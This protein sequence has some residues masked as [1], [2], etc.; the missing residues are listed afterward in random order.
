MTGPS[1]TMTPVPP[2]PEGPS[3]PDETG[4]APTPTPSS[5]WA[6]A[7]LAIGVVT[8][9]ALFLLAGLGPLL[10]VITA[11]LVMVMVHELGHFATAKWSRMKVTEYFVGFGP[12]LWSVR[13]GET[14]YGIKAIPAGGYV[15]IPGMSNM[16]EIDPAEED[17][18][19]RQAPFHNRIIVACAGSFMHFLMAFLLA[20]SA[21]LYFGTPTTAL[22]VE[23]TGFAHWPGHAQTAAQEAGLRVGDRVTAIN[24]HAIKETAKTT[25]FDRAINR[26]IGRPLHL[27]VERDGRVVHLTVTPQ[28]GHRVGT[29]GEAL[30]AG[31]HGAIGL[32]GVHPDPQPIFVSEGAFGALG[33]AAVNIGQ[34]TSATVR[35]VP[36]GVGSL[37]SSIANPKE[38]QQSAQNGTRAES[39][40]GA[41]R[42]A[43]QAEQSGI[44]Y[45]IDILIALNI[46]LGLLNMLPMLPL[47]G[48]HVAIAVYERV[49][50]RRGRPYYQAD[51]K[52]LLPVVYAFSAALVVVVVAALYLD[53]VHPVA[54]PF[55]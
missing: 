55:P 10:I 33:T 18:T 40:V 42:T 23:V 47:D 3:G 5:A 6:L 22:G 17:R 9:V 20:Y 27:T 52:K 15:K 45:L 28:A 39:I 48:G 50:T 4:A 44:L 7:R 11:V 1:S 31:K 2:A 29:T 41:V 12:R 25:Q 53:I 30:G 34:Y 16:E 26:S 54:N 14:D 49:R 36:K 46:A 51:V 24:G 43:T 21:I 19:Y 8:V 32:I 38:A 35:A 13:R 37:F